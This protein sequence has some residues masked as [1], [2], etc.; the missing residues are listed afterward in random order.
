MTL[1]LTCKRLFFVCHQATILLLF[2]LGLN[3]LAVQ[4]AVVVLDNGDRLS[5]EILDLSG[6]V[7]GF[8]SPIYGELELPW[9][10]VVELISDEAVVVKLIDGTITDG[11]VNLNAQGMLVIEHGEF[12]ASSFLQKSDVAMFNPPVID[13]VLRLEGRAS[14]G[15]VFNRGNSE[16]DS[17]S[18]DSVIIARTPDHRY[19]LAAEVNE[20]ESNGMTTTSNRLLSA[21]YDT[22]LSEKEYLFINAK[23][24]RDQLADLELRSSVGAG[25]GFQFFETDRAKMSTEYGLAYIKEEYKLAPD[26]AFPSLSLGLKYER[27]FW[28]KRLVF[29]NNNDLLLSLEDA[30]DS[31]AK[32]KWGIRV[33]IIKNVNIATQ[34]NVD[35]DNMPPPGV[36]HTDTSVVFNIG[37]GF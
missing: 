2:L 5:G 16:D 25:Y 1:S 22:F 33:P 14:V 27:K 21:Q 37:L 11:R 10:R 20:A 19:T 6:N 18:F 15:G 32:M 9:K 24:E 12:E 17:L 34:F 29:F 35:Y 23:G 4:S 36:K 30:S 8:K 13:R 7:L 31:S 28:K 3:P 26:E